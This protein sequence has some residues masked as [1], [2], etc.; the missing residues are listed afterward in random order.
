MSQYQPQRINISRTQPQQDSLLLEDD[1][2]QLKSPQFAS[3]Q[4]TLPK[5]TYRTPDARVNQFDG[6]SNE[7]IYKKKQIVLYSRINELQRQNDDL[8]QKYLQVSG[9]NQV[10]IQ[11]QREEIEQYLNEVNLLKEQLMQKEIEIQQLN[12]LNQSLK[13]E[14][15]DSE[16]GFDKLEQDYKKKLKIGDDSQKIFSEVQ[17]LSEE[18][19]KLQEALQDK[20]RLYNQCKQQLQS[21]QIDLNQLQQDSQYNQELL[22]QKDREIHELNQQIER[23]KELQRKQ[24]DFSNK[25]D[26]LNK[27]V[28]KLNQQVKLLQ[29]ENQDL[30]NEKQLVTLELQENRANP[31]YMGKINLL[32]QEVE[33]LNNTLA[34][35]SRELNDYK[36]Q[37]TRMQKEIQNLRMNEFKLQDMNMNLDSLINQYNKLKDDNQILKQQIAQKQ[38]KIN[39][40]LDKKIQIL[41]QECEKLSTQLNS[42]K[43]E[44]D[45]LREQLNDS[46]QL[47]DTNRLL[48][49]QVDKFQMQTKQLE[50]ERQ[51]LL[52]EYQLLSNSY[53][54]QKYN[55]SQLLQEQQENN[56][57]VL[58]LKNEIQRLQKMKP[59]TVEKSYNNCNHQDIIIQYQ[60]DLEA[61][62][63]QIPLLKQTIQKLKNELDITKEFIPQNPQQ[64]S[65]QPFIQSD[66]KLIDKLQ[67]YEIRFPQLVEEI[68]RLNQILTERNE[69]ILIYKK[70]SFQADQVLEKVSAYEAEI[71]RLRQTIFLKQQTIDS[72]QQ[73]KENPGVQDLIFK[74]QDENRR[75]TSLVGVRNNEIAELKFKVSEYEQKQK[76]LSE[77]NSGKYELQNMVLNQEIDQLN[78]KLLEAK[79]EISLLKL[80]KNDKFNE[81]RGKVLTQEL[82]K[83]MRINKENE[84]ELLNLRSK[85]AEVVD[86]E[87]KLIDCKCLLVLLYNEIERLNQEKENDNFLF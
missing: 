82:E 75:L 29:K 56:N 64:Q 84:K 41:Q 49:Q 53:N 39:S 25:Q 63:K 19:Q 80:T 76:L 34:L 42:S 7:E 55:Y 72:L 8:R 5:S 77:S 28:Q 68:E 16:E 22:N 2:Q 15:S 62:N 85:F 23:N 81:E 3:E 73:Q 32:G 40:D 59:E 21:I 35:K 37:I 9:E 17:L 14:V 86:A 70:S 20:D 66:Q 33:R 4:N 79:N 18:N 27:E 31:E 65:Q 45:Y 46:S 11:E 36:A 69:Q 12:S 54:S 51:S 87:R 26:L 13:Q 10:I 61:A 67:N 48:K 52:Q 47:E 60:K 30:K 74:L 6:A 44:N 83:Q 38:V 71:E 24:Q 1:Y 57:S 50:S 78:Q 43:K 58:Q